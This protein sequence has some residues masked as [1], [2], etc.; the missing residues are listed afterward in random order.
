MNHIATASLAVLLI[1]A[2]VGVLFGLALCKAASKP[3]P[4]PPRFVRLRYIGVQHGPAH[5]KPVPLFN[6]VEGDYTPG[7]TIT[8]KTAFAQGL[9]VE[10]VDENY[11]A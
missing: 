6:V 2:A 5:Y 11:H 8:L 7:S 3:I 1:T 9:R 10:V 4:K